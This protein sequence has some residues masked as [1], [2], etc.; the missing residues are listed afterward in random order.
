MSSSAST[1][2][3]TAPPQKHEWLVILPDQPDALDRRLAVRQE[4]LQ[5]LLSPTHTPQDFW[6]LGG[7]FMD[8]SAPF[9][10]P[11]GETP[12]MAGSVMLALAES[13][14]EVLERLKADVYAREGVWEWEK[15][16]IYP[17]KSAIRKAL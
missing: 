13:R 10:P 11:D 4:H 5:T 9:P 14:E 17:F 7:A 12:K 1:T 2:T 6:L 16:R 8:A 15:V 3:T